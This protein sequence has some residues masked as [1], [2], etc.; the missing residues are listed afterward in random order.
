[1]ATTSSDADVLNARHL[2]PQTTNWKQIAVP[3]AVAILAQLPMLL[4]YS[5]N[6]YLDK[7]HYQTFPIA[8]LV[9]IAIAWMR[10]PREAKMPFHRSVTSDILLVLGLFFG[11]F[12][13]VFKWPSA[14]AGSAM[15]L[16]AS[17]LA[18]TVDKETLKS[19]WPASLPMFVFLSLPSGYDVFLITRLQRISAFCTSRL[20]DLI[21]LGHH[22]NGTV[23]QVPGSESFGIEQA[24]SGVQSF[25]TLLFLAV[26]FVVVFRR[27]LFRSI[28]LISSAVFW[29]LLMNTIRIF[30]I[31][32]MDQAG[33]NLAHGFP[34]A[35][36]GWGTLLVGALL[37]VSTDQ[38]LLF[39]FGPVDVEIGR[40]GPFGRLI[41]KVWNWL[42]AGTSLEKDEEDRRRKKRSRRKS[43]TSAG[44]SVIWSI[45]GL[46][47]LA[48]LWS[49][50]DVFYAFINE[51]HSVRFFDVDVT[52]PFEESDL[53]AVIDDWKVTKY[54]ID[55][56][57]RGSDLGKRSDIWNYRGPKCNAIL[58]FDQPFPGWHELT[59]CYQNTGWKLVSRNRKASEISVTDEDGSV[60]TISW[61]YVVAEFEKTTGEVGFLAFSLFN[62]VG[63]PVDPPV[64]WNRLNYLISGIKNRF[65]DRF[66]TQ[67]FHK[68][69]YQVQAFVNGYGGSIDD[70]TKNEIEDRYLK[71]REI[72]R[73]KYVEKL[74]P[75]Q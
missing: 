55:T 32:V 52:K 45:C 24:C 69:T 50:V 40:S 73:S 11:L 14:A 47:T 8:V 34:H 15:L 48:G 27:P 3:Y 21:G 43:I 71:L 36:L 64:Q 72:T 58:S 28:V 26:V 29:A 41:T 12:C 35:M 66:R 68:S 65:S 54:D 5:R 51:K 7:P 38:F 75:L 44:K 17:L 53:P 42:I 20:L 33:F 60:Q 19:L 37:L 56:R 63:D 22:M 23:I 31:P 39:L 57:E 2:E 13:V 62:T 46:L 16:G 61:P 25:F 30:L 9:T 1:M 6:L 59:T 4:L 70:A 49:S 10:W 74:E 67:F 18:R